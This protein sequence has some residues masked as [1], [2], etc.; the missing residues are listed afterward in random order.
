MK[1]TI[2]HRRA[3][4]AESLPAE[5][6]EAHRYISLIEFDRSVIERLEISYARPDATLSIVRASLMDSS[7]GS[8]RSLDFL[9]LPEGR[10]RKLEDRGP[11]SV[12]QNLKALPR[13]WSVSRVLPLTQ[14][15]VMS[16]IISGKLTSG[17]PFEPS[18]TALL[19]GDGR[20]MSPAAG[21]S[22][23]A[24]VSITR[25]EPQHIT[26]QT[27][28][29]EPGFLVL[30]EIYYGGWRAR[31]DGAKADIYRTDHTLRGIRVPPGDHRI[32]LSYLPASFRTGLLCASA[33]LLLLCAG[34]FLSRRRGV[35][36]TA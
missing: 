1:A 5:G 33:G 13:A 24:R 26:L 8:A 23:D 29:A 7:T 30:S 18:E 11:V 3:R 6:F 10:W 20:S 9:P 16:A 32:E 12:Y 25:Y 22:A 17:E 14:T 19:E 34:A 27:H 15:A 31:I 4:I 28:N 2:R 36:R 21:R 35:F